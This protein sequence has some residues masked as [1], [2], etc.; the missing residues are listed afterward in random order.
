MRIFAFEARR[1]SHS[2]NVS[3]SE[4]LLGRGNEIAAYA[5]AAPCLG[6]NKRNNFSRRI[7]MFVAD[8]RKR[9]NH[10]ANLIFVL[11]DKGAVTGVA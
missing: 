9:A 1:Q 3:P 6:N 11:G 5:P 10:P 7:I 8:V 4:I 2:R